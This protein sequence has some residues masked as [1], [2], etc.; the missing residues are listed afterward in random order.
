M[1]FSLHFWGCSY[2]TITWVACFARGPASN[3]SYAY[4]MTTASDSMFRVFSALGQVAFA[5]AGHGVIL[6]I[7]ATIPSTPTKP[8]RMPMW[9]GTVVAYFITA[10]CYF[11]VAMA[12]YWTFGQEVDDNV[13]M[14]LKRPRW[15]IAAAN[16]MVVI[17]VIGSYQVSETY[18]HLMRHRLLVLAFMAVSLTCLIELAILIWMSCRFMQC[19]SSTASRAY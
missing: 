10:L 12:G 15:L 2:S 14:A 17:H 3:V 11:P 19:P 18:A 9:K 5:Y 8:S 7:Q 6:E 16:L 4:K 13:L 1:V